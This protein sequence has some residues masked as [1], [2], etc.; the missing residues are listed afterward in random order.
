MM[1]S[2]VGHYMGIE[3]AIRV[4]GS[5]MLEPSEILDWRLRCGVTIVMRG[6]GFLFLLRK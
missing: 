1:S 6:A 3:R 4:V 2:I 5:G